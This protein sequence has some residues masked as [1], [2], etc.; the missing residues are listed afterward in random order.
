MAGPERLDDEYGARPL[1]R[2]IQR[3]VENVLARK[4]LS[5][6]YNS[7]DLIQ[8]DAAGDELSFNRILPSEPVPTQIAQP[9]VAAHTK[10]PSP[11]WRGT[12]VFRQQPFITRS[13]GVVSPL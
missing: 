3:Q 4:V 8:V 6:D 13:S 2:L 9:Q 1:R 5:G 10:E 12:L 7:G 11:D